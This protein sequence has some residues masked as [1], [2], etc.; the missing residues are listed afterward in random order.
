MKEESTGFLLGR[1]AKGQ[2]ETVSGDS[3]TGI[4]ERKWFS[5]SKAVV[6]FFVPADLLY[7]SPFVNWAWGTQ[8]D[9]G[10]ILPYYVWDF[11]FKFSL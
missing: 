8:A 2:R 5:G 4:K 1:A 3:E 9:G 10:P 6:G 7:Y 11:N